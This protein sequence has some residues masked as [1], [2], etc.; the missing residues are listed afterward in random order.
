MD[1]SPR[2]TETSPIDNKIDVDIDQ[3][4]I[5]N[6]TEDIFATDKI[7]SVSLKKWDSVVEYVYNINNNQLTI[8]PKDDLDYETLYT[9]AIPSG[10]VQD[11]VYN[12]SDEYFFSF[13]TI[14]NTDD[15][16]QSSG[17]SDSNS[18][19]TQDINTTPN[20]AEQNDQLIKEFLEIEEVVLSLE[21]TQDDKAKITTDMIQAL[22]DQEKSLTL[23]N[24][25]IKVIFDSNSLN[26]SQF[27]EA[28]KTENVYIE[29]GAKTLTESKKREML[30]E[31]RF[32]ESI[33]IF[34][35]GGKI[36]DLTA[37]ISTVNKDK[38]ITT[39]KID[40]FTEPVSVNIDLSNVNLYDEDIEKLT[41]VRYEIDE[42]GDIHIVKLGGKY[43]KETKTFTFHTDQFSL[44]SVVKADEL[45]TITMTIDKY[46][47]EVNDEIRINDV[48][49]I[50][51]NNRTMVPIRFIAENLG[52]KVNWNEKTKT[53]VM[54]IDEK[55]LSMTIDKPIEDFDI[56]PMIVNNRTLVPI[57][58]I[59]EKLG[60]TLLW[61][62]SN[63]TVYIVK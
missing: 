32:G 43:D 3:N 23:E 4:I 46:T 40:G 27:T 42:N 49:P 18:N 1:I 54:N 50:R 28:I 39:S 47:T 52:A 36:V 31:V 8:N 20:V 45:T 63:S 48:A 25:G 62:P 15:E 26:T 44:Y 57:R 51:I 35:I 61:F 53:V 16:N 17:S 24:E 41:A 37:N 33:G 11:N 2:V 38:T 13:K 7:N 14:S 6:F 10:T 12:L 5:I 55:T 60:A 21:S 9:V 29:L 56:P 34:E 19:I 22:T 58:Y 30:E 59:S